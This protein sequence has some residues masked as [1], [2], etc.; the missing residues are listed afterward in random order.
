VAVRLPPPSD[1][2][3]YRPLFEYLRDR[4]ADSVALTFADVERLVGHPLPSSARL[5]SDWWSADD[6]AGG[7]AS[8]AADRRAT[9]NLVSQVVIYDRINRDS[10]RAS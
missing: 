1:G 7:H 2:S 6:A 4:H 5:E 8:A 9:V 10:R 3:R